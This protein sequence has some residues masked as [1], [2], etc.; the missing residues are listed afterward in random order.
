MASSDVTVILAAVSGRVAPRR[1]GRPRDAEPGA[2]RDRIL[3]AARRSFAELGYMATTNKVLAD[4]AGV[5]T[6][7]IYHYFESK[8]ELYRAV[9][10]DVQGF[11][12]GRFDA[13]VAAS[14]TFVEGLDT[15]L[16]VAHELNNQDPTLARFLGAVRVDARRNP[17]LRAA[18]R[19]STRRRNRFIGDLVDLGVAC[20]QLRE[21]DRERATALVL[22]LLIG[23]TDAVSDSPIAHRAAVEA[24]HV[25]I[26]GTLVGGR[27][28]A[29]RSRR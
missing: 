9:H 14:S 28:R 10:E 13:I 22:V 4:E 20:G 29:A 6:G 27:R 17:E 24:M 7:A 16:D 21:Q 18:L 1:L 11:V 25:A 5:T 8:V 26:A 12:Y 3:L 15:M 2:T 19:G 23:L